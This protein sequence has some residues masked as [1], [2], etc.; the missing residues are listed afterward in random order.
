MPIEPTKISEELQR[1]AKVC[2]TIAEDKTEESLTGDSAEKEVNEQEAKTWREK[3]EVWRAADAI[4]RAGS[5]DQSPSANK[6]P[7]GH[8]A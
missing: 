7:P 5:A 6:T 3:S 2:E 4:V 1:K 8:A